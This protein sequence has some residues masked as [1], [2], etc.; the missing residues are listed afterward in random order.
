MIEQDNRLVKISL[1]VIAAAAL[2][3]VAYLAGRE[4]TPD[5]IVTPP[6]PLAQAEQ[7]AP[8]LTP[9]KE[10]LAALQAQQ[11]EVEALQAQ[12]EEREAELAALRAEDE[13]DAE[14]AAAARERWR[15]MEAEIAGLRE[16]LAAVEAERDELRGELKSALAEI[17]TQIAEN[18]RV[19]QRARAYKAANTD[20]LWSAFLSDAKVQICDKGTRRAH[21]RCHEAVAAFFDASSQERF[22]GCV[23]TRSAMPVLQQADRSAEVP[24]HSAM[25]PED[26]RFTRKGWYVLYCDPTLPETV[27]AGDIEADPVR[28]ARSR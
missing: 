21:A 19:R 26:N 8:E 22:V 3:S 28:F 15:S 6:E 4:S 12:L 5:I 11:Q 20:N 27:A 2:T 17:D 1:A 13:H 7:A 23:D 14:R 16:Q 9:E 10:G 25:L 24:T 18:K